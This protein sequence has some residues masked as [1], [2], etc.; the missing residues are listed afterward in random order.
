MRI[1]FLDKL[2]KGFSCSYDLKV[3]EFFVVFF[4]GNINFLG[5]IKF[6]YLK[7]KNMGR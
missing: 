6:R 7:Y 1:G 4:G 5:N 3:N 2:L